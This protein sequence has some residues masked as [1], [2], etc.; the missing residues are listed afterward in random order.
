MIPHLPLLAEDKVASFSLLA[1]WDMHL[2]VKYDYK[3]C[4]PY[5]RYSCPIAAF[6]INAAKTHHIYQ[7]F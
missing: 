3:K 2:G 4:I 1:L 5:S 7:C 6:L